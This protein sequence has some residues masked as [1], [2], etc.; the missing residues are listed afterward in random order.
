MATILVV[1]DDGVLAFDLTRYIEAQTF[2]KVRLS[3][4]VH[5]ALDM[6]DAKPEVDI[7]L[8]DVEVLDGTT[9]DLAR[10]LYQ[11]G[12]PFI[13]TSGS[14][15]SCV[16]ADLK[17]HLFISKPYD[18]KSILV[19]LEERCPAALSDGNRDKA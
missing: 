17:P 9:F 12:I 18:N 5:L 10:V 19:A 15:P 14:D 8:L 13:F 6:L 16:P 3:P 7:A 11:K 4:S 2:G 1:E